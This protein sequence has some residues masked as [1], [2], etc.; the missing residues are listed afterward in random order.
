[1][2]GL[3]GQEFPDLQGVFKVLPEWFVLLLDRTKRPMDRRGHGLAGAFAVIG[4]FSV[5][6]VKTRGT[7]DLRV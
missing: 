2:I 1:M 7:A 3:V 5:P 4:R 6:P